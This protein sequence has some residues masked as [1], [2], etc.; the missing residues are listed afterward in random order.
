MYV[1]KSKAQLRQLP[2]FF[3]RNAIHSII[4]RLELD[5]GEPYDPNMYGWFV[6]CDSLDDLLKPLLNFRFSIAGRIENNDY[7]FLEKKPERHEL[8]L[9]LND[10]EGILVYIPDA[11][12]QAYQNNKIGNSPNKTVSN[13]VLSTQ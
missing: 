11:I 5:Y 1:I 2:D 4:E 12:W 6:V 7:E 13:A 8:L 9:M 10:I 3:I